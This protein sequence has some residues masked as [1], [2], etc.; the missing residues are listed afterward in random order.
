MT[1]HKPITL[2]LFEIVNAM[3]NHTDENWP[4]VMGIDVPGLDEAEANGEQDDWQRASSIEAE[5][6]KQHASDV[7]EVC[8]PDHVTTPKFNGDASYHLQD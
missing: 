4:T 6:L 2:R 3:E 5:Y 7:Y 8:W 1:K